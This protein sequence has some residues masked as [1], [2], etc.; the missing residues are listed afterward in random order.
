MLY[1][2]DRGTV[3]RSIERHIAEAG[4]KQ[5]V[6]QVFVDRSL[7]VKGMPLKIAYVIERETITLVSVYPLKKERSR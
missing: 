1:K 2:I 6:R 7:L 5:Q 3:L 4:T